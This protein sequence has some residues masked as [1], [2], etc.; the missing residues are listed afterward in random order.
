MAR[1]RYG[2]TL[3]PSDIPG[4]MFGMG[5]LPDLMG[6][7]A[8]MSPS[9]IAHQAIQARLAERGFLSPGLTA[10]DLPP[11]RDDKHHPW[12]VVL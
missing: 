5:M 12:V 8:S 3:H 9:F 6:R 2:A 7:S 4:S 11:H 10:R 1:Q